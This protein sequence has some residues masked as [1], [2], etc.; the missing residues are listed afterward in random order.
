MFSE[1]EEESTNGDGS[2]TGVIED[3]LYESGESSGNDAD[4]E[5]E[6]DE[7]NLI[8]LCGYDHEPKKIYNSSSYTEYNTEIGALD[9]G[10]HDTSRVENTDWCRCGQCE[11]MTSW[12]ES[13]CCKEYSAISD[14]KMKGT[15]LFFIGTSKNCLSLTGIIYLSHF[16]PISNLDPLQIYA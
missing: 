2:E 15:L 5:S 14:D 10:I 4:I 6:G 7:F 9:E 1:S 3:V 13:T 16:L 11:P 8:G 12:E